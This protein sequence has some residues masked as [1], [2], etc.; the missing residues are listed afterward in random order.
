MDPNNINIQNKRG[1]DLQ[2][3]MD[4]TFSDEKEI[5]EKDDE[6]DKFFEHILRCTSSNE[7]NGRTV[8]LLNKNNEN[9]LQVSSS[10]YNARNNETK[11]YVPQEASIKDDGADYSTSSSSQEG[12]SSQGLN[13]EPIELMMTTKD[14]R[15]LSHINNPGSSFIC[16]EVLSIS[17][18][19]ALVN[20]EE[21]S[22]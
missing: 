5:D 13:E 19:T 18:T 11:L 2:T 4:T 17:S 7:N 12:K 8:L 15:L 6:E 10:N 14:T 3:K 21:N 1:L 20:G 16:L 9:W 22:N